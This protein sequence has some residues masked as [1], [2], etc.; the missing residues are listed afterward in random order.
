MNIYKEH[1]RYRITCSFIGWS[2]RHFVQFEWSKDTSFTI[3]FWS[4]VVLCSK[5]WS[6]DLKYRFY[7]YTMRC[8]DMFISI[9]GAEHRA[10]KMWL[11][12]FNL[13]H[14][15]NGTGIKC[16]F[17]L[18]FSI[19]KQNCK[20]SLFIS[21]THTHAYVY[22]TNII[23]GHNQISCQRWIYFIFEL[24]TSR[25]IWSCSLRNGVIAHLLSNARILIKLLSYKGN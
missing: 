22:S 23:G 6:T 25:I 14:F 5:I 12:V 24:L 13:K 9:N 20:M 18:P 1:P 2:F 16:V 3:L 19:E 17:F 10:Y 15:A 4:S 11:D 7:R 8:T 21:H